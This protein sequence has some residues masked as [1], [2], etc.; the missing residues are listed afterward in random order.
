MARLYAVMEAGG[1]EPPLQVCK[2][3]VLPLPLRPRESV[4][5]GRDRGERAGIDVHGVAHVLRIAAGEHHANARAGREEP[6]EDV[7]IA[8]AQSGLGEREP[9]EPVALP[10]VRA[11]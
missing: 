8:G 3:C 9:A 2:T 11:G 6:V 10:R 5:K 4:E 7:L 1:I